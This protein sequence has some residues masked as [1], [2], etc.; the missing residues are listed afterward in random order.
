MA[1]ETPSVRAERE[2]GTRSYARLLRL[3]RRKVSSYV[4][5]CY[6]CRSK[7]AGKE[8]KTLDR[9]PGAVLCVIMRNLLTGM[10]VTRAYKSCRAARIGLKCT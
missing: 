5:T 8:S 2:D 4:C 6:V 1:D 9:D 7:C 3:S 10:R